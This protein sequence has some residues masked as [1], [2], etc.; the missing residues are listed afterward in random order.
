LP[1]FA[2]NPFVSEKAIMMK[3][4]ISVLLIFILAVGILPVFASA[5]GE[6]GYDRGYSEGM[7][8]KGKKFAMGLDISEHQGDSFNFKAA[9]S[10]G[11]DYVILR[12]G[13]SSSP[14]SGARMDY[15]FERNY[16]AAR[17]AGLDIGV[18]LYSY[19]G[20]LDEAKTDLANF[21][22]YIEGKKFEYP[23]YLDFENNE[24]RQEMDSDPAVAKQ[25][26]LTILDGLADAGYL[27]GLYTYAAWADNSYN[28]WFVDGVD[29]IGKKYDFWMAN[30]SKNDGKLNI[31]NATRYSKKYG[32]HQYTSALNIKGYSGNLDANICFKDY[33]AIVRAYGFNGYEAEGVEN[34]TFKTGGPI[35]DLEIV[36]DTST[37]GWYSISGS[38]SARRVRMGPDTTY[39]FL[40]PVGDGVAFYVLGTYNGWGK[41]NVNGYDGWVKMEKATPAEP[42]VT[43]SADTTAEATTSG[44]PEAQGGCGAVGASALGACVFALIAVKHKKED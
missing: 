44:E 28:G 33:P 18:Y 36:V 38:L 15:H 19:A 11:F 7:T 20:T 14:K 27:A 29:E 13:F 17:E 8:G 30:Y 35:K 37:A 1:P 3:R 12:C 23:V 24:A 21:L 9:K 5:A 34:V 4:F 39:D 43:T 16:T 42:P 26:C 31:E 2:G 41:I 25:I 6:N 40:D 10:A 22:K 32:M